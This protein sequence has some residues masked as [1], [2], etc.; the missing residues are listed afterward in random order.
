MDS[1]LRR[2]LIFCNGTAGP[3]F[4][5]LVWSS[6]NG[7]IEKRPLRLECP[8]SDSESPRTSSG[9]RSMSDKGCSRQLR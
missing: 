4:A 3:G 2:R 6:R 7:R 8:A 9:P 1:V 5:G